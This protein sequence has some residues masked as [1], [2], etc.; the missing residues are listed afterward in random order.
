MKSKIDKENLIHIKFEY[1]DALKTK[2]D[3]LSSEM[4]LLKIM[5][6]I[7]KYRSLRS[8]ELNSKLELHK[9]LKE[10]IINIKKLQKILPEVE[11]PK[12]LKK[13]KEDEKIEDIEKKVK[14]T[15]EY[16]E[17]LESQLQEIQEKLRNLS[18]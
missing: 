1:W 4:S 5:K 12:I 6:S 18:R 16:D 8:E 14:I 7:K 2:K 15:K 13:D 11:M 10:M 17:D 3:I 9:K